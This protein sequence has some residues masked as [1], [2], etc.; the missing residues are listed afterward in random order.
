[1]NTTHKLISVKDAK[2]IV[3]PGY[4]VEVTTGS[5]GEP[6]LLRIADEK[7]GKLAL[8]VRYSSYA[9][10]IEVPQPPPMK[11]M[12]RLEGTFLG[13]VTVKMDFATER[14]AEAQRDKLIDQFGHSDFK[15]T[16]VQVPDVEEA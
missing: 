1:M 15:L 14:D 5:N 3:L 12:V 16:E 7:T 13:G 11:K 2:Q 6:S 4:N 8:N 10:T 9:F